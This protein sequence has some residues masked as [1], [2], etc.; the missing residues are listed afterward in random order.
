MCVQCSA[1]HLAVLN[2]HGSSVRLLLDHGARV[3]LADAQV[4][5]VSD[6][7]HVAAV[8]HLTPVMKGHC[9]F[10][11]RES[12]ILAPVCCTQGDCALHVA[13]RGGIR[14]LVKALVEHGACPSTAN[15]SGDTPLD[16][17]VK[18]GQQAIVDLLTSGGQDGD[19]EKE[20]EEGAGGRKATEKEDVVEEGGKQSKAKAQAAKQGTKKGKQSKAK[21]AREGEKG[22][23]KEGGGK[24]AEPEGGGEAESAGPSQRY[25]DLLDTHAYRSCPE[26]LL[27][28][29]FFLPPSPHN[30][31][32]ALLSLSRPSQPAPDPLDCAPPSLPRV[33][34]PLLQCVGSWQRP[35]P[36]V[37]CQCPPRAPG[38]G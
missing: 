36:L 28:P 37:H 4:S 26:G 27:Q 6:P 12:L 10:G 25:V 15:E 2:G 20:E 13:C 35:L 19:S 8:W 30:A 14:E 31:P 29:P 5:L 38:R 24:E 33:C 32:A 1:L 18:E 16:V 3:D 11:A 9:R 21:A 22:E 7:V 17:A 34:E 23:D